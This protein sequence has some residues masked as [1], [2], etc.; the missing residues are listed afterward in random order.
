MKKKKFV[1]RMVSLFIN[2][3]D[4]NETKRLTQQQDEYS[5]QLT[6]S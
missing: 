3:I 6:L 2:D 5:N 4:L 1:L